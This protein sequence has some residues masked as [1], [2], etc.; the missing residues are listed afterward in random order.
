MTESSPSSPSSPAG[1]PP[2]RSRPAAGDRTILLVTG[3]AVVFAALLVAAVILL[4]TR[5]GGEVP[6]GPFSLGSAKG[7]ID[8]VREEGPVFYADPTGRSAGVWVDVEGG[9]LVALRVRDPGAGCTV[10]WKAP[11]DG[12][13]TGHYVDCHGTHLSSEQIPRYASRIPTSGDRKGL[14]LVDV[15]RTLPAPSPPTSP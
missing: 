14:F 10:K 3:A 7:L 5:N 8:N 6:P 1:P 13:T 15:R 4:A 2:A 11:R 12:E 9:R